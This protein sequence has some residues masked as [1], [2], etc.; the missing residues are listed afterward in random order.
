MKIFS[1]FGCLFSL[2]PLAVILFVGYWAVL[3]FFGP[4]LIRSSIE[5]ETG[6]PTTLESVTLQPI[7]GHVSLQDLVITNP[8]GYPEER[9]LKMESLKV[10]FRLRELRGEPIEIRNLEISV[11]E[12]VV[13]RKEDGSTNIEDLLA[14]LAEEEIEEEEE[15]ADFHLHRLVLKFGTLVV[16]DG[17]NPDNIRTRE[18]RFNIEREWE[19]VRELSEIINPLLRDAAE[20]GLRIALDQIL[21]DWLPV[22]GEGTFEGLLG[23]VGEFLEG[24][25]RDLL[26]EAGE[27]FR[28]LRE[29]LPNLFD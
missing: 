10:D 4:S 24:E 22:L 29:R 13:V 9:F 7:R 3:T 15:M 17:R 20:A 6:F 26:E 14:N 28:D 1:P 12:F 27:T 5:Q 16:V 2:L 23:D 18:Y 19:D 8:G 11:P 25:G 21:E